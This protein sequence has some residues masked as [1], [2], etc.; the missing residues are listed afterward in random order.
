M[1]KKVQRLVRFG[2]HLKG[3]LSHK[4]YNSLPDVIGATTYRFNQLLSGKVDWTLEEIE[5]VA[6]LLDKDPLDLIKEWGLGDQNI[7][8][9]DYKAILHE[10]GFELHESVHAA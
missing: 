10:R 8:L 7:S 3:E 2:D 4:V 1:N 5:K 6:P 9:Y